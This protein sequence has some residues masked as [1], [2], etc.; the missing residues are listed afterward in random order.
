MSH[1][2]RILLDG[3]L[4]PEGPRWHDGKLWFRCGGKCTGRAVGN[5]DG[6]TGRQEAKLGLR[7]SNKELK[8]RLKPDPNSL[9][10]GGH[11]NTLR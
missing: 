7:Q 5:C 11:Y 8:A 9:S 6:D 10:L 3:L 2:T 1:E 4:F